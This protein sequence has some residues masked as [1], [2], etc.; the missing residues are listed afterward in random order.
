M[1]FRLDDGL[2]WNKLTC[3]NNYFGS[4]I[5]DVGLAKIVV[6]SSVIIYFIFELGYYQWKGDDEQKQIVPKSLGKNL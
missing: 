3:E 6:F 4:V 1:K 5:M 2:T